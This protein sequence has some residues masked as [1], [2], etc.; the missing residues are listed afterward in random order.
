M[1]TGWDKIEKKD[2]F[3]ITY[4]MLDGNDALSYATIFTAPFPCE[5]VKVIETHRVASSAGTLQI[6]KLESAVAKG[7]GSNILVTAFDTSTTANT[8][9]I[10]KGTD[11]VSTNARQLKEGDRLGLLDGGTTTNGKGCHLTLYFKYLG[12]GSYRTQ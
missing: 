6:E 11:L 7:N 8:P 9:I 4:F 1:E 5:L 3:I 10:K 12:R 2:G